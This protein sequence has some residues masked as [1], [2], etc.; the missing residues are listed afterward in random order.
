M[1]IYKDLISI[2]EKKYV[3]KFFVLI[4][5]MI[6]GAFLETFGISLIIPL[7]STLLSDE[8]AL[9]NQ[10]TSIAPIL[11][12]SSKEEIILLATS[13]FVMFYFLKSIYLALLVYGQS[14]YIYS[15]QNNIST[16]LYKT[17]LYQPYSFHLHRNSG[18]IISN[19]VTEAMQFA[20]GLVAPIIYIITDI[21][22]IVCISILLFYVE[23]YGA[24]S[25]MVLFFIGSNFLYILSKN[26]SAKWGEKR[27][28]NEANRIK[29]A[30]QGLS[31]IKEVK[32]HGFEEI[33]SDFFSKS[34]NISLSSGMK[35]TTLQG[36]P[37]IFFEL[38]TVFAISILIYVLYK[39]GMSSTELISTL[40]VFAL[41]AFKLLPSVSRLVTNVQA[42]RF[43]TP[44]IK[45]IKHEIRLESKKRLDNSV[46]KLPFKN[47]IALKNI[48][49][50]YEKTEKEVLRNINLNIFAGQSIGIIGPSGSGKSTL[51]DL[52]LGL[53]SPNRGEISIDG[54]EITSED[55][56]SWQKNIGYVSQS[57]FI[58][59]DT[60]RKNIAF[61]VSEKEINDE[62]IK[63][64]IKFS[65]LGELINELPNGVDSFV[66]EAGVRISGGQRQ[67]IG[68]ARA[69]YNNPS[70]LVFDEAT[71]ALDN[72]TEKSVMN[73]ITSL[74]GNKTI[75][76]I[77]H[78][79]TTV[80]DCDTIIQLEKGSIVKKGKPKDLL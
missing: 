45:K 6:I 68:I 41:A 22:I 42:L 78:R 32:L 8:F 40:G 50:K 52:I 34:T 15:L 64:A 80:K 20:L 57:I 60:F 66:G 25:V 67:R 46:K 3:S 43:A 38:L 11:Q 2:I 70:I 14:R 1:K 71:S 13:F 36:M 65:Q 79:L 10:I 31:G 18:E 59:D 5:L 24:A 29:S 47:E 30:Q 72:E 58:L 27:Q 21:L 75:I 7:V 9:P 16:R 26:R 62:R 12:E 19:S 53:L 55:I 48:F 17:Y 63:D 35:Q 37:K 23:P 49:F 76:I 61:G 51:V 28:E 4:I 73:S 77:A 39:S 74:Q 54:K 44:V 33:F 56:K 69:L